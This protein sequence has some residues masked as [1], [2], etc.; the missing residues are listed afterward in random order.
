MDTT[1]NNP[2]NSNRPA[3]IFTWIWDLVK[4]VFGKAGKP[5][6][7]EVKKPVTESPI[8]EENITLKQLYDNLEKESAHFI[9][10]LTIP[11]IEEDFKLSREYM[12]RSGFNDGVLG[13]T[14]TKD[15]EIKTIAESRA[16]RIY[17]LS[18]IK[19]QGKLKE[20]ETELREMEEIKERDE[21]HDKQQHEYYNHL[22]YHF[23]YHPRSFSITL[24][25]L[26]FII[27]IALVFADFPLA[28]KLIG[29]GLFSFDDPSKAKRDV[30]ITA[31][32]I[33]LCSIYIKI[34]Y[35]EYIGGQYGQ[36]LISKL[37][38]L[39][40]FN[41][42]QQLDDH[43]DLGQQQ[44]IAVKH[45]NLRKHAAK[46]FIL[47]ITLCALVILGI[48]RAKTVG[49]IHAAIATEQQI[50]YIIPPGLESLTFITIT[51]LFPIISGVCLSLSL[52]AQQNIL[53]LK[54]A[55]K[56][57]KISLEKYTQSLKELTRI[58]KEHADVQSEV[59]KWDD[60]DE[61]IKKYTIIFT[62][63][64]NQ[65]FNIGLTQPDHY[66]KNQ[67]FFKK[68]EAWRERIVARKINTR[69]LKI[70]V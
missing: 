44:Q 68:V 21:L 54:K 30:Y 53:R 50:S 19:L 20:K 64:Y 32:G 48:Y 22:I 2:L 62:S 15:N 12:L 49:G 4:K 1:V 6:L 24:A 8:N 42:K 16:Q 33:S 58:K 35:D 14:A 46:V 59:D 34:F 47:A 13:V 5:K 60:P 67:S 26:Y 23:R 31:I 27:A 45:G 37:K 65:A 41:K 28:K 61:Q 56:D 10:A 9:K 51:L 7:A 70:T 43:G 17:D 57:C 69:V 52:T 11:E 36:N 63:Y 29:E 38:F 40:L 3:N 66:S 39:H 18:Q 55:R 25:C